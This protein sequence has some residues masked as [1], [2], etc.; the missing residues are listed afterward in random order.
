[1]LYL[2]Y[3]GYMATAHPHLE[4]D[5][6]D[7]TIDEMLRDPDLIA[8]LDEQHAQLKRG[9]LEVYSHE[10]V[11]RRLRERGVPLVDDPSSE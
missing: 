1:V 3:D 7:A 9:E 11:G 8:D 5:P 2:H 10:E 6:F 4:P